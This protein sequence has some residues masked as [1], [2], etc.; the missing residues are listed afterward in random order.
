LLKKDPEQRPSIQELTKVPIIRDALETLLKEFEDNIFFDL[1]NSLIQ[2][3]STA[4]KYEASL[5]NY[6]PQGISKIKEIPCVISLIKL[7]D[8]KDHV[9]FVYLWGDKLYT[10][11][12]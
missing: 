8:G 7:P 10:E 4:K 6:V 12:N 5:E 3:D 9:A 1:K 11:A 2:K